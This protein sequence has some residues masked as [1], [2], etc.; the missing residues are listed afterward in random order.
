VNFKERLKLFG[1]GAVLGAIL[2]TYIMAQRTRQAEPAIRDP[3]T[4][5][6][7]QRAAVPGILKAYRER[8]VP[9]QSDFIAA[10]KLYA[11]PDEDKY[12]RILILEG[13]QPEQRLRIEETI[14]KA[15]PGQGEA[16][17][18]IASVRVMAA[19]R[20]VVE[21]A[22]GAATSD[23]AAQIKPLGFRLLARDT[24]PNSLIVSTPDQRPGSVTDAI[25]RLS[26]LP[27]VVRV[28]PVFYD[29]KPATNETR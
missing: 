20:V 2:V 4:P 25:A 23:L 11:H 6:E 27:Q 24:E 5:E 1:L 17:E 14:I 26:P 16:G 12:R 18:R 7:I 19:D 13:I 3:K 21:L 10:T 15:P 9:M 28:E 8:G 29:G 22:D